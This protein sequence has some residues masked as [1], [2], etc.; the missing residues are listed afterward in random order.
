MCLMAFLFLC[1]CIV[2]AELGNFTGLY[3]L[4]T[5]NIYAYAGCVYILYRVS[6]FVEGYFNEGINGWVLFFNKTEQLGSVHINVYWSGLPATFPF[7]KY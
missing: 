3:F 1:S 6:A 5:T 2:V 4:Y 7:F